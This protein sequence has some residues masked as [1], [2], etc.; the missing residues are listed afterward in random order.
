MNYNREYDPQH[1]LSDNNGENSLTLPAT[2]IQKLSEAQSLQMVLDT[3]AEWVNVLFYADRV[4]LTF[5]NENDQLEL[6]TISGSQ[7]IP[8]DFKISLDNTFVGKVYKYRKLMIC[9]DVSRSDEVDCKMLYQNGVQTCMDAPLL[10]ANNCIGTLNVGHASKYFYTEEHAIKLQCLANWIALNISLHIKI[11]EMNK[12][13]FSD[14]LTGLPNRRAFNDFVISCIS[15]YK[16]NNH[17]FHLGI[18]DIDKFKNLNDSY[19]HI[20]GDLVLSKLSVRMIELLPADIFLSRIGGEEFAMI[21]PPKYKSRDLNNIYESLRMEISKMDIK[22][23]Q[24]T[25]KFTISI[26]Y[27]LINKNDNSLE[28]VYK[29]A[30]L[31]LYYAKNSGRNMVTFIKQ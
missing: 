19:G 4:S 28:D 18:M 9:D 25:I 30:D 20:A 13:A 6:Y 15:K 8:L 21:A 14:Y 12:L 10:V 24:K 23:M 2:F 17:P 27:T 29:R 1:L 22:Y 31:A 11:L 16:N 7:A 3:F 26:G 5:K